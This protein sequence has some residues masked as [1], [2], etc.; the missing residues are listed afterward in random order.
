[1]LN[2]IQYYRADLICVY[3]PVFQI[4]QISCFFNRNILFEAQ[5][6]FDICYDTKCHHFGY[7]IWNKIVVLERSL[8]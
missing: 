4:G 8:S 6:T 5:P 1:M 2:E 7:N 3:E